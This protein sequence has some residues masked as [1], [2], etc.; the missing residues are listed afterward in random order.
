MRR[1]RM[2]RRDFMTTAAGAALAGNAMM[3]DPDAYGKSAW[4]LSAGSARTVAPSD[5]VR[6]G[7]IGVGM[8]GSGLMATSI[9]LPGVECVAA[10]DLYDGRVE[11]AKEIAEKEI[12]TTKRYRSSSSAAMWTASSP[13][14]P[15]TGTGRLSWT[16][17]TPGKTSI[18]KSP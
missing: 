17:A 9:K 18:A 12:F 11:L 4:G 14:F 10:C 3:L 2:T 1:T 13:R 5:T 15:T 16:A 8:Q 7:I 6:F